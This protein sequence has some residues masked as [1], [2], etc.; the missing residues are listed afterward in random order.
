MTGETF[1]T[2]DF[3]KLMY[4]AAPTAGIHMRGCIQQIDSEFGKGYTKN[5]PGLL[6]QMVQAA[7]LDLHTAAISKAMGGLNKTLS[8]TNDALVGIADALEE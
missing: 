5:N 6:G 8:Y 4:D 7:A 2:G 3:Y 1:A